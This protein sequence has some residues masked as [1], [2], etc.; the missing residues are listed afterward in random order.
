MTLQ[1]FAARFG[2]SHVAVLKWEQRGNK[3]TGMTW[4]AEKDIRLFIH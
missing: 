3:P 2:V 1:A 4:S